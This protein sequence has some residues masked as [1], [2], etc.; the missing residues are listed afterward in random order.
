MTSASTLRVIHASIPPRAQGDGHPFS[1]QRFALVK[2]QQLRVNP[3]MTPSMPQIQ[4]PPRLPPVACHGSPAR[5][6]LAAVLLTLA[7]VCCG[8]SHHGYRGQET[9]ISQKASILFETSDG[10]YISFDDAKAT[11]ILKGLKWLPSQGVTVLDSMVT[12][13]PG[14]IKWSYGSTYYS[15][16]GVRLKLKAKIRIERDCPLGTSRISV[17]LPASE[18]LLYLS[19]AH[20]S[21]QRGQ[22]TPD[23]FYLNSLMSSAQSVNFDAEK[24]MKLLRKPPAT[25][26][27]K[28]HVID[29]NVHKTLANSLVAQFGLVAGAILGV[30][31]LLAVGAAL[32]D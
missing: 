5:R 7:F 23:N 32:S 20:L 24:M 8:C 14:T 19:G 6:T 12:A 2:Q 27:T 18:P 17:D 25:I 11:A 9:T 16:Q 28:A 29:L 4:V 30:I 15:A 22:D 1:L 3:I 26:S 21:T 31:I 13:T 10:K